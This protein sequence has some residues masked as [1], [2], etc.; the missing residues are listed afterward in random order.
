MDLKS[1]ALCSNAIACKRNDN[2]PLCLSFSGVFEFVEPFPAPIYPVEHSSAEVTCVAYDNAGEEIP[3][4]IVFKRVHKFDRLTNVT[5]AGGNVY[6]VG[7]T[8]G[9]LRR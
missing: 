5:E 4:E 2:I 1:N 9:R 3:K 8:E 6:F 7:R